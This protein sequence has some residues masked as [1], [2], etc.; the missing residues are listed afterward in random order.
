MPTRFSLLFMNSLLFP[1]FWGPAWTNGWA[2]PAVFGL[3]QQLAWNM[4][5]TS[6][7]LVVGHRRIQLFFSWPQVPTKL[8]SITY[9]NRNVSFII[10]LRKAFVPIQTRRIL[11]FQLARSPTP[12]HRTRPCRTHVWAFLNILQPL[13]TFSFSGAGF[14]CLTWNSGTL[15]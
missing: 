3:I 10:R 5:H 11:A 4:P 6:L 14:C 13:W 9:F 2:A 8:F 1:F 15:N 7:R 12:P